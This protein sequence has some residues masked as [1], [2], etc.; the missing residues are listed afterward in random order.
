MSLPSIRSSHRP[1]P[2]NGKKVKKTA[3]L[4]K[5]RA[6]LGAIAMSATLIGTIG[7]VAAT[8]LLMAAPLLIPVIAFKAALIAG[9]ALLLLGGIMTVTFIFMSKRGPEQKHKPAPR[10]IHIQNPL[11]AQNQDLTIR[12]EQTLTQKQGVE[13]EKQALQE[14][15]QAKS[16]EL[17]GLRSE[18]QTLEREK[19]IL[20]KKIDLVTNRLDQY[21]NRG[22]VVN[23]LQQTIEQLK[24][25]EDGLIRELNELDIELN[26]LQLEKK[27]LEDKLEQKDKAPLSEI[28]IENRFLRNKVGELELIMSRL[29]S[30]KDKNE[31]LLEACVTTPMR[32]KIQ[33]INSSHRGPL[34][35]RTLLLEPNSSQEK[36]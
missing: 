22:T 32:P 26:N 4:N 7:N 25:N 20:K 15:S 17:A 3:A 36:T 18:L 23:N 12:L 14:Q 2:Q 34:P 27:Q 6:A 5:C 11:I 33:S 9:T 1:L 29:S 28:E 31:P 13:R 24:E 30:H 8:I 35:Y 10:P 19:V 21:K 16:Q